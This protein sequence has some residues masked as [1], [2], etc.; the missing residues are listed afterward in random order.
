M[1]ISGETTGAQLVATHGLLVRASGWRLHFA[2]TP[3]Y[4][5]WRP[6]VRRNSQFAHSATQALIR[7][8]PIGDC[9]ARPWIVR[10]QA[11]SIMN[12]HCLSVDL[13]RLPPSFLDVNT[14]LIY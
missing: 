6:V 8:Q 11:T 12:D 13:K 10:P 5:P 14:A 4:L 1:T 9:A 3:S 7:F 2:A